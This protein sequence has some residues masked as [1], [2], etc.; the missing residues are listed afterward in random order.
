MSRQALSFRFPAK[1]RLKLNREFSQVRREGHS[2]R[3]T[4]LTLG[5][6]RVEQEKA[7]RVGF[8][9]SRRIG[10]AVMRNRVRRKLREIVRRRQHELLP[11]VWF[12]VIAQP[13]SAAADW[14]TLENEWRKLA[15]R[16]GILIESNI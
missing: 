2:I 6:L 7:F 3:G 14:A 16:A 15:R 9:T 5:V 4:L 11:G 8:V 10:G 13:A 1:L 12:V